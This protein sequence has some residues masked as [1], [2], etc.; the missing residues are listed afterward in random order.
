MKKNII[1]I[2]L[3]GSV[4]THINKPYVPKPCNIKSLISEIKKSESGY[5]IIIGHGGGSFPH[6]PAHKYKVNLGFINENSRY[7]AALTQRSA[8]DLNKI[9]MKEMLKQK[10]SAFSF[11][12]SS[13]AIADGKKIVEWDLK[14]LYM[15]LDSGFLPVTYGDVVLDKKQGV[16]IASTEEVF[17]YISNE[18]NPKMIIIGTDVD[19]VFSSDPKVNKN[20]KL[21]PL[22]NQTNIDSIFTSSGKLRKFNVTGGMASKIQLLYEISAKTGAECIIFNANKKGRLYSILKGKKTIATKIMAKRL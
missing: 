10:I 15:A 20:S 14:P 21:I 22:I 4:I 17:R 1:L 3:G 12:P 9:I 19:G 2:K 11:S 8:S 6:V 13:G 7:G 18:I 16:C 5:K